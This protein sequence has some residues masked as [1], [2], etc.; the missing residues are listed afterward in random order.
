[1]EKIKIYMV[2]I[3]LVG[4]FALG[5]CTKKVLDTQPYNKVGEDVVWSNTANV[6]TFIYST[7][8]D[9][10]PAFEGG[11]QNSTPY[12]LNI[13]G[14]DGIY[15]M[16]S[17]VF[18]GN[19]DH[20]TDMG[21]DNWEQ[22][23]RCNL[24]IHKV[25]ASKAISEEDK[26]SLIAQGKFLR[27]MSYFNVA[28]K[29]GRIVWIDTVLTPNDNLKLPT[30][31][32]PTESYQHIIQ[33]LRAA[34]K[35]L[36]ETSGKAIAN[37][38]TAAAWLS[39]VYLEAIAYQNYPDP[40]NISSSDPMIDSAIHYANMVINE[41]GYSMDADYGGMFNEGNPKSDEIIQGVYR[42][43]KNTNV[44]NTPMQLMIA[45]INNGYVQQY[46]GSPLYSGANDHVLEG[47]IQGGPTQNLAEAYLVIDKNDPLKALPW[48]KTSQYQN[49]I[50]E[51]VAIP[52]SKIPQA[53]GETSIEHGQIK[54]GSN[55]TIWTLTNE[56]RDA[57]W[58]AS[59]V[60]DS[61]DLY[62]WTITTSIK[63]NATRWMKIQGAAYY[64][65]I[66]NLYWR[67]GMYNN[68]SPRPFFNV[69][70][71]YHY[72][73]MRLGRVYLNL[74]EAYLLKN[75]VSKAVDAFNET[76]TIHGQLPKSTASNLSDAWT[77]YKR[78]RRVDLVLEDD[79][80]WSLLRWG[81]MGGPANHGKASGSVIPELTKV[82]RVM[83]ISKDRKSFSIVEGS[84]YG[85]NDVRGFQTK[86]YL[87][88]IAQS[89]L[90]R[91]PN[92]GPQNTGW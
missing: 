72:V 53:G 68:I 65:S 13:L 66:S 71:D 2:L 50:N 11:G 55:E 75:D 58:N 23:R 7:Y 9:I 30:T 8:A 88:P 12:T 67:K 61:T 85:S 80:Y 82:P 22:V 81:R 73:L 19:M 89:Y 49:A 10:M 92:F 43:A 5:S 1:M 48:D 76:R 37:K 64:V 56:G 36:P 54:S 90:D 17:G 62:G 31:K 3:G 24:I 84:F 6:W 32:N 45:N 35:N 21:F 28:R 79:Y 20:N 74:A 83:D 40:S 44:V 38:Y 18:S 15:D 39:E 27:A 26:K 59:I 77:D 57:R 25:Q 16:G 51:N 69:P 46:G 60:S 4:V 78:E 63:G 42:K 34:I 70:T 87:F 41:G 86:R 33:D 47:W 52:T 29:I 14:F 91:N